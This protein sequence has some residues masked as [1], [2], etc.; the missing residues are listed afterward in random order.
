MDLWNV[1]IPCAITEHQAMKAYWG[2]EVCLHTFLTLALPGGE[3]SASHP[4][5]STPRERAPGT[6]GKGGWVGPRALLDA[7]VKRKIPC[8]RRKSTIKLHGIT[9]LKTSTWIFTLK[10]E[11][12]WTTETLVSYHINIRRRKPDVDLN[13]HPEDRGSMDR[14]NVGILPQHYTASQT[15]RPRLESS[16]WR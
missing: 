16:P 7:V 15:R 9:T 11:A 6:H 1:G 4:G 5:R 3:W 8:P 12:A 14:R 2:V 10:M 13:L